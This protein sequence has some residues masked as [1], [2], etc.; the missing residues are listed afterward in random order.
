M[1]LCRTLPLLVL[2]VASSARADVAP[3]GGEFQVNTFTTGDQLVPR[4][5]A[6]A[7]GRF[8]V[9]WG[10][11][12]RFSFPTPDGSSEGIGARRFDASGAP[13][14]DEFVVNSYTVGPQTQPA[15]AVA[16]SG[17]FVVAWRGGDYYSYPQ[18]GPESGAFLQRLSAAGAPLGSERRANTTTAGSQTTPAVSADAA[19]NF[20]VVWTSYPAYYGAGSG[21]GSRSGVFG[22]RFDVT[23]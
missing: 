3:A 1:S 4:V 23:G 17:E 10:S 8:T 22:Q 19:G 12:G 2:L 5:A 20:V 16:P 9:T 13:Q 14:G 15:I 21:D 18:D 11:G 7:A 6:D